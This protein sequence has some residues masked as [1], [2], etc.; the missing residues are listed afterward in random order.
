[1]NLSTLAEMGPW[2][3]PKE[4]WKLLHSTLVDRQADE[5]ERIIAADLAGDPV[6]M[7]DT[8]AA[9]LLE[10]IRRADEPEELR[11]KAAISLGP[12][13]E[14][15]DTID[16]DELNAASVTQST[17]RSIRDSLH[18]FYLDKGIPKEVR[19]RILEA[20]VRASEHWH[21]DAIKAAYASGDRDW[22]LTAVFAMRWVR[23]FDTEI[24]E[25]LKSADLEIHREA[26]EAAGN[27][28]LDAA[29]PHVVELV[30]SA[31]TP[32]LLLLAAIGAVA[33]IR[34]REAGTILSEL[35]DSRD[36]DISAAVDEALMLAEVAEDE[37][38]DEEDDDERGFL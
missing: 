10:I 5:S 3:W 8:L 1:M 36:E 24:L 19:R 33:G 25:A 17:F 2:E 38:D 20:S 23:G 35:V 37:Q 28:E 14:E 31:R 29:W 34:P 26:V 11:A 13:L 27:W 9:D 32:K 15:T 16:F 22:I 6:V 30:E 21:K 18:R 12:V 4:T 7:N